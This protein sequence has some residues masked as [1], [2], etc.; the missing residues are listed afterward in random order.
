MVVT[1]FNDNILTNMKSNSSD[2]TFNLLLNM[3]PGHDLSLNK[4]VVEVSSTLHTPSLT[5]VFTSV[6][7]ARYS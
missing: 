7:I 2:N 4:F 1:E 6:C 5:I 3:E